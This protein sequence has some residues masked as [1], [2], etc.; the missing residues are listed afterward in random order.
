M[1][2][3]KMKALSVN[4]LRNVNGGC[5]NCIQADTLKKIFGE[6]NP[7]FPIDDTCH[8]DMGKNF[9]RLM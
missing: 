8:T 2:T 3:K 7:F 6:N 4:E 5:T 1:K 9:P